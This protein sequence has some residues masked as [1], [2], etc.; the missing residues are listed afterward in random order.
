MKYNKLFLFKKMDAPT[1][2]SIE[3]NKNKIYEKNEI[4]IKMMKYKLE[5][6]KNEYNL[7]ITI[8]NKYINFKLIPINDIIF[9]YYINKFDLNE[10]NNKLGLSFNIND[11]L[12]KVMKLVDN[13]FSNNKLSIKF[14]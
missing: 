12:E 8:D 5:M 2:I 13:C 1:P 7:I 6:N 14:D 4:N 10:I 11:N 3:I 9:I